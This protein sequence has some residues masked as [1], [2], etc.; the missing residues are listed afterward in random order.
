M[1]ELLGFDYGTL[2]KT[3]GGLLEGG[4]SMVQQSQ[5]EKQSEAESSSALEKAKQ[6]DIA[7][8]N[9]TVAA[10]LSQQSKSKSAAADAQKAKLAVQAA[11]ALP[12]T[13]ERIQ[14]AQDMLDRIQKIARTKPNDVLAQA[15]ARAW[16]AMVNMLRQGGA[17]GAIDTKNEPS[18]SFWTRRV[19]GPFPGYGVVVGGVGLAGLL[20]FIIV[21]RRT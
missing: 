9:A 18:E 15:N 19:L 13:P 16:Q 3:A 7:A 1:K 5:S 11:S 6:A 10:D 20:A 17:S 8:V 2:F 14:A 12:V 21:R 4:A